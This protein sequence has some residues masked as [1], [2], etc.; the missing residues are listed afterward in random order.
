MPAMNRQVLFAS[1][2][3]G[4]VTEDNFRVIDAPMPAPGEG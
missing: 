2:P 1:R 3:Q 4:A